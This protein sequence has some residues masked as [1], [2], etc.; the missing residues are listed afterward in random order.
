LLGADDPTFTALVERRAGTTFGGGLLRLFPASGRPTL[1]DWN[2]PEG[3]H[4]DWPSVPAAVAFASDWRGNLFLFDRARL[5]TGE[6]KIAFLEVATGEY[7]VIEHPFRGLIG[8]LL[9]GGA[10]ELLGAATL[11][12]WRAIG[13]RVPEGNECV[14][15][16]I[17]LMLGGQD[18]VA[19]FE[20]LLLDRLWVSLAGQVNEQ[21]R[22][23]PPGTR[24]TGI[25]FDR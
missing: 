24:V 15:L 23:L 16:R 25:R 4:S 2:G 14:G 21:T 22:N 18:E 9:P 1:R 10:A 19:N 6:R 3:W 17:P 7:A 8:E 20:V 11:G 12:D 13:G 5:P